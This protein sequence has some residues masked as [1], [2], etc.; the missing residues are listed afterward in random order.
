MRTALQRYADRRARHFWGTVGLVILALWAFFFL[1]S[2]MWA[3][4]VIN[5]VQG[6]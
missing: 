3:V 1:T 6:A 5:W 4:L 2:A